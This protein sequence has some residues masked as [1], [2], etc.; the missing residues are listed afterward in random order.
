MIQHEERANG[1]D[2]RLLKFLAVVNERYPERTY[3][4]VRGRED[5]AEAKRLYAQ[6]RTTP[7]RI[8]TNASSNMD[9]AHGHSGALDVVPVVNG[10][11]FPDPK[12]S[13]ADYAEW[14]SQ[15]H[16]L[17]TLARQCGLQCGADWPGKLVDLD[18][19]QVPDWRDLPVVA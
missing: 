17:I 4:V 3:L 15:L 2:V 1:S 11:A 8:V 6:G 14:M 9:S 13:P 16:D 18:H 10:K 12:I 19:F 5:D 7:G